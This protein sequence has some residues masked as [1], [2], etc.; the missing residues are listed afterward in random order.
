MAL[1][2]VTNSP[3]LTVIILTRNEEKHIERALASVAKIAARC[4][5]IDSGS[6][7]RTREIAADFGAIVL[8]NPWINYATQFNW[9]L[10]QLPEDTQWVLRLDA[11]EYV[12][13]E[14]AFEVVEKLEALGDEIAAINVSRSMHFLGRRIRWGGIF[15]VR[16]VRLFR[17]GKGYCE[18]RWMDEHIIVE[19]EVVDFA[20]EIID[21]NLNALTWWSEKHNQYASREVIDLLNLDYHFMPR[22]TVANLGKRQQVGWKR[23]IKENIYA[24]SPIGLRA[25]LYF[26][27]RYIFRLGFL[28]GREGTAFHFLQGFWYRYLVDMKYHEVRLDMAKRNVDAQEAILEVLGIDLSSQVSRK[29]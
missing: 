24:R 22:E 2:S 1:S 8:Q 17:F 25:L 5:I 10:A 12:T 16:I 27:Y 15:P 7:D 23:W 26:L 19:G 3:H 28:D 13:S 11:D 29:S 9:A 21:D 6:T 4:Y 20:G 18:N 14:L